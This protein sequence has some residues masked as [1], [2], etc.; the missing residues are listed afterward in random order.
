MKELKTLKEIDI[1]YLKSRGEYEGELRQEAI[2]WVKGVGMTKLPKNIPK[3]VKE[4]GD[5]RVIDFI[6]HFFNI[7]EEELEA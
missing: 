7:T 6:K 5:G 3:E 4:Y 2:K 1:N